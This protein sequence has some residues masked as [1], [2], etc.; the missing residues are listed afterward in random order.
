[1]T[2]YM[3]ID[4]LRADDTRGEPSVGLCEVRTEFTREV[5]VAWGLHLLYVLFGAD[6]C[7]SRYRD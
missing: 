7:S 6:N 2:N 3:Y 1:M 4:R 5:C